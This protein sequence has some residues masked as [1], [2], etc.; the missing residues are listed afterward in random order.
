MFRISYSTTKIFRQDECHLLRPFV[1]S[2]V[3]F[4]QN[5]NYLTRT[6]QL[7]SYKCSRESSSASLHRPLQ[8]QFVVFVLITTGRL[9]SPPTTMVVF[10]CVPRC[11][12][13]IDQTGGLRDFESVP[14]TDRADIFVNKF[15]K[16]LTVQKQ[17][18]KICSNVKL[19][20]RATN[21]F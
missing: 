21:T 15:G 16:K 4:C 10:T 14:P 11:I 13:C 5:F 2:T 7:F 20:N 3:V 6:I 18:E 17:K 12:V 19:A 1:P 9:V 8:Q